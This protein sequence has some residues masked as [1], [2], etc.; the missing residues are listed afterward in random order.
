MHTY[1]TLARIRKSPQC[2][3]F[4]R[5]SARGGASLSGREG[6]LKSRWHKNRHQFLSY[7]KV[8]HETGPA[9]FWRE[10]SVCCCCECEPGQDRTRQD[11]TGQGQDW[12][13]ACQQPTQHC[14]H[15]SS[16][17]FSKSSL[18]R[19]YQ[20]FEF[21]MK[22]LYAIKKINKRVPVFSLLLYHNYLPPLLQVF[23]HFPTVGQ[24]NSSLPD[25]YLAGA[26]LLH[27]ELSAA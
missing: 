5:A 13:K 12:Y 11:K 18:L 10:S 8:C 3:L 6:N 21:C 19:D 26:P 16:N 4:I 17:Q 2:S 9:C 27:P 25:I 1:T 23:R 20:P 15:P 14:P 7:V 24:Y 22:L